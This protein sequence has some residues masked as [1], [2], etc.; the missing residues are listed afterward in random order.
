MREN[1]PNPKRSEI[2]NVNL[3]PTVGAEIQKIRPVV[4]MSADGIAVLPLRL[5]APITGWRNQFEGSFFHVKLEP[6]T[7]N[8]LSKTSA[9]DTL[10]LRG[11]DT[12]RF[13]KRL[14]IVSAVIMAEIATSIAMVIEYI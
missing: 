14:G 12:E 4:V 6:D 9:V 13:I 2:W 10:Q 1:R 5:V 3:N 11:L 8:G 7:A